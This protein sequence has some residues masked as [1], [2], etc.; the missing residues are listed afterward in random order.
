MVE[1]LAREELL[2][3]NCSATDPDDLK[4]MLR[5]RKE[6]FLNEDGLLYRKA[7]FKTTDKRVNQ[8]VMPRQFRKRTVIVC[9]EDYGHLGM[10]QVLIL[11]QERFYW[12]KISEDVHSYIR[13]CERCA[14]FK[15]TPE[16]E[17]MCDEGHRRR[18][19]FNSGGQSLH[20]L[21]LSSCWCISSS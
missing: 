11:L 17:E 20:H 8:F 13:T 18:S 21:A 6:F 14:Q 9:H 3:Y 7:Y 5:M 1:L 16:R 4:C 15:Q 12:P 10:D 2:K 19:E